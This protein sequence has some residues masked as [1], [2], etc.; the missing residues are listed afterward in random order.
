[1]CESEGINYN[2]KLWQQIQSTEIP[3]T[4]YEE[5]KKLIPRLIW[6]GYSGD[7]VFAMLRDKYGADFPS[8]TLWS[9]IRWA[10]REI[11]PRSLSGS[12]YDDYLRKHKRRK[13]TFG[14]FGVSVEEKPKKKTINLD[15][16][17]SVDSVF[18]L[19][20]IDFFEASPI[21]LGEPEKDQF[22]LLE[23]LYQS[24]DRIAITGSYTSPDIVKSREE[25]LSHLEN[26]KAPESNQGSWIYL[27][28]ITPTY[29]D[30]IN[31]DNIESFR[32]LLIDGDDLPKEDQLQILGYYIPNIACIV[33]TANRGYH[34]C[35][36][37]DVSNKDEYIQTADKLFSWFE[38]L[39]FDPQ[40]KG[41]LCKGRMPH[42]HR[43]D[44]GKGI[45]GWQ[46]LIY[47]NPDPEPDVIFPMEGGLK[48]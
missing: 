15:R 28:P 33:D 27:N 23:Q 26:Y 4:R 34:A 45:D 44:P 38:G 2:Q 1:M 31:G 47:L 6:W 5:S 20:E 11:T 43:K 46:R 41:H 3:G 13:S 35:I 14:R 25:W 12:G 40:T 39:G 24:G 22:L 10:E 18:R 42:V 48:S 21:R 37:V 8:T 29:G 36:K 17:L 9:T 30:Y 16:L 32:Y 7:Q 19:E